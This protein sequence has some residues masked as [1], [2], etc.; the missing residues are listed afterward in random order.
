MLILLKVIGD[1]NQRSYLPGSYGSADTVSP[2]LH[3]PGQMSSLGV[4]FAAI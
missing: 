1:P 2:I 3:N 4:A